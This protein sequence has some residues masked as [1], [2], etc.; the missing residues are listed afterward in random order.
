MNVKILSKI[1]MVINKMEISSMINDI[2]FTKEISNDELGKIL[3]KAV[4]DN[5][6]KAENEFIDLI[7][8]VKGISKEEAENVDV[9]QFVMDLLKDEKIKS[10]LQLM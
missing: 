8:S 5:F 1:S 2:D 6:Y 3:I 10:F 7:A 4:L 9:I